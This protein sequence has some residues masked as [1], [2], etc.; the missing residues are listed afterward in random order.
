MPFPQG[1]IYFFAL[2]Q[3]AMK[4]YFRILAFAQPI[5][6]YAV[7]Y[8][9]TTIF[10][11]FF[12][13]VNFTLLIPVLDV[14]FGKVS[15]QMLAMTKPEFAFTLEFAQNWF[16]YTLAQQVLSGG[17]GV[18][19]KMA[20]LKFICVVLIIS[21]LLAN[22]F[23]YL[24]ILVIESLRTNTLRNLRQTLFNKVSGLHWGFFSNERKGDIMARMTSDVY[25]VEYSVASSLTV[26]FREPLTI[27]GYFIL[28]LKISVELT[29]FT[30]I[31]IPVSGII[32]GMISKKLKQAANSGQES[33]SR[34]LTILDE[35]LSGMRV[36]KAFNGLN[37]IQQ[38]FANEN[39]TFA[40]WSF[41][42]A[43]RRE[44]ASPFSEFT[45]VMVVAGILLYGGGLV[46]TS[47]PDALKASEF[48]TYLALFSQVLR[49]AKALSTSISNIQRGIVSG[50]RI[51]ALLDTP[52]ELQDKPNAHIVNTFDEEIEFKNITFAYEEKNVLSDISFKLEKG[53][54]I[55]LVGPSGGGKSTIADL[56]PRF[57]DPA[58]GQILIDGYD[59]RD[60]KIDSVR[61]QMGIVT[62]ESILFNDTI[63]NN[64]AFCKTDATEEEVIQAAKIANAHD[65]I[66]QTENGYQTAIG[67]RGMKLSGGQR[68]RLNIARAVLKN[69]AVLI[70]DEATSA[71]DTESEKLVQEA[72]FNLMQ[73]R[74]SLVIAHRLSTIQ[75][76]DEILVIQQGKIVER[77]THVSLLANENGLYRRLN[78]MQTL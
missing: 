16:N 38:K 12:G 63:F 74:T 20:A 36:I 5:G 33:L 77:G 39:E 23:K 22:I 78:M 54:T 9:F 15:P 25:E 72:L 13:L 68:Q 1:L 2:H 46:I 62:Q 31:V 27:I 35:T 6:K 41:K 32:I 75:H 49:P 65:F 4:T 28:L 50:E 14:L 66:M 52:V 58:H 59:I 40:K 7:P 69:P 44:Q 67:D 24:S 60:C 34:T 17:D 30:L 51:F 3:Q 61:D 29:M 70:L 8:L 64:I 53:K 18:E 37:Y 48:M 71:L 42:A 43:K 76:A 11:I 26:I 47:S 21:V 55:A 19:G 45:S 10:S 57:Y 73:N 56:L